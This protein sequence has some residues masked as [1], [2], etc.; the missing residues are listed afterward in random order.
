MAIYTREE[1]KKILEKALSFSK[2]DA[3]EINLSGRNSGNIRYARNTVSTAGYQSNQSLVVQSSFGKKVGTATIDEF[4]DASLEK[5]VRRAEELAQLSPENPEFMPPLGPQTYDEAITY[6]ESTANITPEYRAEVANSSIVPAAANDVTAAGF[7]DDSAQFSA[8]IN[9]NGLFAYN[10]S[11]NVDFTVTMRTNDGTGSGWVTRDYNDID[12]FD[13]AEASKIAIDKAVMSREARAIEPGKY[14][15]ILEPAASADLLR[16][17]FGSFNARSA[18]EGRSFMSA[19]DG[20]NKL[21]QKIVDERVNLWSDPLHPDVPTSTW[22]GAGQP[23]KKTSWIEN[24]VVKNLAYDRYWAEQ[25]GVEPVPFPSNAIMEG[26]D[27]SLEDM[28]KGTKKGILVTRF[29]YIRS[30]DPQT[31]LYTGLTRDGTFYIENGQIKF[32]VKN[33]RFNES[34][35]IMLNNLESLGQ[36]VRVN[37]N[38]IPYMKIRDFT[39]TSLSDAV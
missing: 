6:K 27:E 31:L 12:K 25:K 37:G 35:I 39:F 26:G 34:P 18:D 8:M 9:S 32:P 19:K 3:C 16:N 23:L 33:F 4:D 20:G 29:W 1:A 14:T 5:V 15:V 36:Q 2:A 13:A 21:G 22:N 10:Q 30:V 24:G 17:M 11:T 38:L 7:L 28:I